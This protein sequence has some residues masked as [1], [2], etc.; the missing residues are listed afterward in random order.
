MGRKDVS[1]KL[2]PENKLMKKIK[3]FL[4]G[5]IFWV[6]PQ[7]V[8][9]Q[10]IAVYY[11]WMID[12]PL[13]E[14]VAHGCNKDIVEKANSQKRKRKYCYSDGRSVYQ[15]LSLTSDFFTV[16]N[17]KFLIRQYT[18][19]SFYKDFAKDTMYIIDMKNEPLTAAAVN[20]SNWNKWEIKQDTM[21]IA[22]HICQKALLVRKGKE[23]LTAWYALDIPIMDGPEAFFGLPG[24]ILEIHDFGGWVIRASRV[25][26]G[27]CTIP[28]DPVFKTEISY[29]EYL[30][31][32]KSYGRGLTPD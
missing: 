20:M 8:D 19:P 15:T 6:A 3:L 7:I 5:I 11:D 10:D 4:Y 22:G 28:I 24:L 2:L 21:T 13:E 30:R 18:E 17:R 25:E 16:G 1:V 9:A 23:D 26:F 32:K 14:F 12:L 29:N 31:R 27:T